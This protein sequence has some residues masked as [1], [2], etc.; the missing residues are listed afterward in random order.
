MNVPDLDC[1]VE[2]ACAVN[3]SESPDKVRAAVANVLPGCA[4]D[5]EN[6]SI[7][8]VSDSLASLEKIR[9]AIMSRQSQRTYR[10]ALEKHLDGNS[11]WFYLNKQAAFAKKV[12]ICEE[13]DESP[14]GPIRVVLTSG[15]IG[16]VVGWLAC[17]GGSRGG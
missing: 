7:T 17:G 11:T 10:R 13:A 1:K 5:H 3:P 14:L 15:D 12:A 9:E 4:L 6:F 2:A 8:A 16:G